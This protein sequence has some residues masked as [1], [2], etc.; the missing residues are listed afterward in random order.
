ML[1]TSG[2]G[3]RRLM[4]A[5]VLPG[6]E[7]DGRGVPM[8]IERAAVEQAAAGK[9]LDLAETATVLG[10]SKARLRRL[11]EAGV[12]APVHRAYAEGNAQLGVRLSRGGSLP[13]GIIRARAA[14]ARGPG[15]GG[16]RGRGGGAP[17][18]TRGPPRD[19]G[20]RPLGPPPRIGDQRCGGRAQA[21]AVLGL[22]GQGACGSWRGSA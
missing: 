3:V 10:I 11:V 6:A 20:P 22:P 2:V 19:G 9:L 14:G 1:G 7:S 4:K 12:L 17:Q 15:H 5:G 8:L 21:P 18:A 16:L 13:E